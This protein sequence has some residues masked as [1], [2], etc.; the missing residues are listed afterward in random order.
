[1]IDANEWTTT[2]IF[3]AMSCFTF[4]RIH[5]LRRGATEASLRAVTNETSTKITIYLHVRRQLDEQ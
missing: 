5:V 1:M 3:D 4:M 2:L